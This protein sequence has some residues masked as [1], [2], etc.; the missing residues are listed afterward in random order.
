MHAHV[1]MLRALNHHVE[2]VLDQ[3]R[4]DTHWGKT[5]IEA[6]QMAL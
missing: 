2:R 3:S 1:G 5:Q 6:G 4:K